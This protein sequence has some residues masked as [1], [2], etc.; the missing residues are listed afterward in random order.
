MKGEKTMIKNKGKI[1]VG[2]MTSA[3]L[4]NSVVSVSA[5]DI[6]VTDG[7]I[8]ESTSTAFTVDEEALGGGLVVTIPA[9]LELSQDASGDFVANDVV[10]AYGNMNPSKTLKVSTSNEI[11]YTN[12]DAVD[13]TA[14]GSVTFGTDGTEEWTAEQ[15]RDS[16]TTLD[17][18]NIGVTVAKENIDYVGTY[19]ST[20]YFNIELY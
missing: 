19:N 16:I 6:S 15:T 3:L 11:T 14:T 7:S 13:I 18:R 1:L 5:A 8:T 17:N 20:V 2:L 9:S 12:E 4:L 10:S